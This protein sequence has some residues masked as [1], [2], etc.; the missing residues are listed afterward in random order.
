MIL[1]GTEMRPIA[2]MHISSK[3]QD[4]LSVCLSGLKTLLFYLFGNSVPYK[5]RLWAFCG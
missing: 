2:K 1:N 3:V 4:F 5:I